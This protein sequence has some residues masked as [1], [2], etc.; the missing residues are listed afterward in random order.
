MRW[1]DGIT[2]SMD[3]SLSK[4]QEIVKGRE[5]WCAV[6]CGV[7]KRQTRLSEW[8]IT[9]THHSAHVWVISLAIRFPESFWPVDPPS[10]ELTVWVQWLSL[11]LSTYP[12]R[13]MQPRITCAWG[14][15]WKAGV[16]KLW[17]RCSCTESWREDS[18][19]CRSAGSPSHRG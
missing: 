10:C 9:T 11:F 5:A 7:A 18:D 12:Q 17:A 2:N 4:L 15:G 3:M 19:M 6:V 13:S 1:L 8:S 16:R 14:I